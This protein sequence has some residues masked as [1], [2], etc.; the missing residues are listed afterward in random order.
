VNARDVIAEIQRLPTAK[1]EQV[2]KLTVALEQDRRLSGDEID[3]LV[4]RLLATTDSVEKALLRETIV[5]GFYGG[6]A[7]A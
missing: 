2:M 3:V 6:P 7:D 5:R 1:Q 4:A